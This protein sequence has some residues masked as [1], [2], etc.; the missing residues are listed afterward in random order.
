M[1]YLLRFRLLEDELL[2]DPEE[3]LL[4]PELLRVPEERLL[5]P[6]LLRVPEER[7]LDPEL[8]RVPE[9]RLL[10]PELLRVPEERLDPE[11]LRVPEER[12]DPELLRV[13]EERLDPELV[14]V[15]EERLD[16]ELV[17]VPE[18]RLDPEL[19]RAPEDRFDVARDGVR[20]E[21]RVV[22]DLSRDS[23]GLEFVALD[24]GLVLLPVAVLVVR[25]LP[26]ASLAVLSVPLVVR[27]GVPFDAELL[28]RPVLTIFLVPRSPLRADAV[29]SVLLVPAMPP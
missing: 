9:E 21:V 19:V 24:T 17:R 28:V 22:V 25:S 15:P 20:D 3:R 1:L 18:E 6:E 16:P 8:L 23:P 2:R 27:A 4:D 11:L 12:L 14:R 5:D 10:D 29:P 26:R 7:L 13:P